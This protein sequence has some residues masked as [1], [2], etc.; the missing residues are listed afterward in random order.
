MVSVQPSVSVIIPV[1]NGEKYLAEAIRSVLSQTHSPLEI[2]V[3]DDGSVDRSAEIAE[4]YGE[5]VRCF[6]QASQ[7]A[8]AARNTGIRLAR[9]NYLAFLDADDW[10][11]PHKTERQLAWLDRRPDTGL[12]FGQA[13]QFHSPELEEDVK[14]SLLRHGEV[15]DGYCVGTLLARRQ[16]FER[17]GYFGTEWKVAEFIEWYQRTRQHGIQSGHLDEVLVYRRMHLD[18]LSVREKARGR[19]EYLLLARAELARNRTSGET[20][21]QQSW[22]RAVG[23]AG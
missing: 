15:F 2:L 10:W 1:L 21:H 17:V 7:G 4:S 19:K 8:A 3:V 6:R 20:A 23:R 13:E 16:V 9:G 5:A 22:I 18:N 12:L 11:V 14:R